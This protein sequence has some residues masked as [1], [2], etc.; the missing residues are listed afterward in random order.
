MSKVWLL[1]VKKPAKERATNFRDRLRWAWWYVFLFSFFR[2]TADSWQLT[3]A[4]NLSLTNGH[5]QNW[6]WIILIPLSGA[7][8]L[9]GSDTCNTETRDWP[10]SC[11]DG[12]CG[13]G[14]SECV[15]IW[16]QCLPQAKKPVTDDSWQTVDSV[17]RLQKIS[18]T[19]KYCQF[20]VSTGISRLAV[21]SF[22][23]FKFIIA[24]PRAP[25]KCASETPVCGSGSM[26]GN[27]NKA[28]STGRGR[29]R[30]GRGS[31]GDGS[32]G[33]GG[34]GSGRGTSN[35]EPKPQHIITTASTWRRTTLKKFNDLLREID[36][37]KQ[38]AQE[39]LDEAVVFVCID[40]S[41]Q[42]RPVQFWSELFF[43]FVHCI[44]IK[45]VIC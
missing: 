9:H 28:S 38:L 13:R 23:G 33:R 6:I 45:F 40:C 39:V 15:A 29:G 25:S 5:Y 27:G 8:H 24:A 10:T 11:T 37:S 36:A 12:V 2:M 26:L 18:N 14:S 1:Q 34:R 32:H 19:I 44:C 41:V 17:Q 31:R 35:A 22:Q 3:V 16:W 43:D 21:I 7:G 20:T 42:T 30:G 4:S